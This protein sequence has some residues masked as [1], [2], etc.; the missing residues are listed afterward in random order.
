[1]RTRGAAEA[2]RLQ[3][4]ERAGFN[5][6]NL[7]RADIGIDLL[8]DVP[9]VSPISE[10]VASRDRPGA[11]PKS[12]PLDAL[13]ESL[14]GPARYVF[15]SKG[16]AAESALA[17]ASGFGGKTILTHGLFR[18]CARAFTDRGARVEILSC[19][20]GTSNLDLGGLEKRLEK[21]DVACVFVEPSNNTLAGW[22]LEVENVRGTRTLCDRFGAKLY[23]DATRIFSN[24]V[25]LDE[26][27]FEHARGLLSLAD[28]FT[29]SCA[30][31]L[32]VTHG[33]LA[34]VRDPA[35]QRAI[36]HHAFEE[37]T[38]LDPLDAKLEL[39]RGMEHVR[40]HPQVFA[41]RRAHLQRLASELK[42]RNVPF[43]EP[44]GAHAL[45]ATPSLADEPL[46]AHALQTLLY[47]SSG[48]RG[49]LT[50]S[51]LHAKW[52]L[53]VPWLVG[54]ERDPQLIADALRGLLDRVEEAPALEAVPGDYLL[55]SIK[56]Y[57]VR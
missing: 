45:Y 36:F 51:K 12:P 9:V 26:P 8:T 30:K 29:S 18:T 24:A 35:M 47:V 20:Q 52:V 48:I 53:R 3:I 28:A 13:A 25:A 49:M 44:L 32:L 11:I 7:D 39:A 21:N 15:L 19:A 40:R 57:R 1:M 54:E 43:I 23:V 56:R 50:P 2:E 27:I 46:K 10:A 17:Q 33:S 4:I 42:D 37:G 38:L 31:E 6:L 5:V 22:A 41:A 34:G 16:R 55:D 14:Y